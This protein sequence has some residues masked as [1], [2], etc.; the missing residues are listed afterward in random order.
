MNSESRLAME[1][2]KRVHK[3]WGNLRN[4]DALKMCLRCYKQMA[5]AFHTELVTMT[6][7]L[8]S[9]ISNFGDKSLKN[10]MRYGKQN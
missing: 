5:E 3:S 8:P 4:K 9:A 1:N 6:S 2:M 7:G 10:M